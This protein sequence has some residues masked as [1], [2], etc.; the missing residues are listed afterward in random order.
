M[1]ITNFSAKIDL[2]FIELNKNIETIVRT[3]TDLLQSTEEVLMETDNAIRKLK[4]FI[5]GY[6]FKDWAE[7]INFFKVIKPK[8]VS[9]YIYHSKLLA[10][11]SSRPYG[12]FE[13]LKKYY[14]A[15]RANLLYFYQEN[16][17]FISYYRRKAT[18][19]DKKYF[20]RFKFDFKL[21]LSPELYNYD[22]DFTTTHDHTVSQLLANDH[23][24]NY[25][26]MKVNADTINNS[27]TANHSALQW[28]APKVALIEL[29]FALHQT[30]C[31]NGGLNDPAD[32]FK[33]AESTL[34]INLGNYHK[35]ISEIKQR[36]TNRTK[37]LSLIQNNM[38]IYLDNSD[39]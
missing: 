13:V 1:N 27:N 3:K 7:E 38:E 2:L 4:D 39:E 5:R 26:S 36:K 8:F 17:E 32:I 23:L 12:D 21:K 15:E 19:L 24:D 35:T 37:F 9:I 10:I 33:W 20:V 11:E 28:T 14:E 16:R 29:L 6:K 30:K 22:E 25:L 31:F 18:Y 34:N